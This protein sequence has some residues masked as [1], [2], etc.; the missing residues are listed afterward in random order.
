[1]TAFT[2]GASKKLLVAVVLARGLT[3]PH[4]HTCIGTVRP[5]WVYPYVLAAS[6][7][8]VRDMHSR[9]R[10]AVTDVRIARASL[11][12]YTRMILPQLHAGHCGHDNRQ[13]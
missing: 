12:K 11:G 2:H 3:E 8:K 10:S 7:R 6:W 4:D 1:V 9:T 13:G 5:V